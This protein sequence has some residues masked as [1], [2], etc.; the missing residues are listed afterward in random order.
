[1]TEPTLYDIVDE[2]DQVVGQATKEK[3]HTEGILHRGVNVLFYTKSGMV[4]LQRRAANKSTF[5]NMLDVTVGGHVDAGETYGQA[6]LKEVT[7]ETGLTLTTADLEFL[8]KVRQSNKDATTGTV[9]NY[10]CVVYAF[11]YEAGE[12]EL[13]IESGK[14]AG[15]VARTIE[16]ILALTKE[17]A[18][19]NSPTLYQE[20]Y[21][22]VW[23]KLLELAN[24]SSLQK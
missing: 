15:F 14:A 21:R 9:S 17:T 5:P 12:A 22:P 6:A 18:A 23:R 19:D 20:S 11:N 24:T 1:M 8:I 7:E 10:F 4:I 16:E 13:R 2:G 3:L